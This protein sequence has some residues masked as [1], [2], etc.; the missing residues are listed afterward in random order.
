M[1][2][3]VFITRAPMATAEFRELVVW[4]LITELPN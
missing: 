3:Y 4:R 2:R 1:S